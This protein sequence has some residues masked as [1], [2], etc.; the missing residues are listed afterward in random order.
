MST[1]TTATGE[2]TRSMSLVTDL[3]L[4][5][6]YRRRRRIATGIT[7]AA[8]LGIVLVGGLLVPEFL[9]PSNLLSVLRAASVTGVVAIGL[10]FVTISGNYFS[11]S[12]AQTAILATIVYATAASAG[13][14]TIGILAVLVV[15]VVVGLAQGLV[16]GSGGNPIV[17]TL[18]TGA[19]LLGIVLLM[20]GG[21]RVRLVPVDDVSLF[22]QLTPMGVPFATWAFVVL[23]LVCHLVLKNTTIGRRT[24]LLGANRQTATSIGYNVRWIIAGVFLIS[25]VTAGLAG[26][27]TAAEFGVTDA[28]QFTSLDV[29]AI[30]AVLV[31]GTAIKGGQ[32][33]ILQTTVGVVFI[34]LLNN[35]LQILGLS[36]GIRLSLI[37]VAV[38]IAVVGYALMKERSR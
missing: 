32:G 5:A 37:G 16:V 3:D 30:A 10:T 6:R 20:T 9:S 38:V 34:A 2:N 13:G 36:T 22:G 8:V 35:L 21:Q 1:V 29:D 28:S 25:S 23:A 26:I 12:V 11:L 18:A 17:V 31:G 19:I 33:S 15:C 4:I 24:V 7:V 14:F 27:L